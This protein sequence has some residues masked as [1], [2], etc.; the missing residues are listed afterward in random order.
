MQN[1][2]GW[3]FYHWHIEPSS[4][5]SL[6]C[7]RCPR[8]ELPDTPWLQK[9]LSLNDFKK[10]FDKE[11]LDQ[12]KRFTMCGDVGDP[13]YC[14]DYL[15]ILEHIKSFDKKIQ[16]FTITNGS[17]KTKEWWNQFAKLSN[18]FILSN[19]QA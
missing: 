15:K 19:I 2:Y 10:A 13:I 4:K 12:V 8:T 18:K 3:Q 1:R 14:K 17:Y 16:I 5:C 11:M 9:E 6:R 7:P